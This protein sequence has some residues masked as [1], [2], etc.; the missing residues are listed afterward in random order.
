MHNCDTC[1]GTI[2]FLSSR[3]A[4][5]EYCGRLFETDGD[6]LSSTNAENI[7]NE[8]ISLLKR[9]TEGDLISANELF[10][11]LGSYKDSSG[12]FLESKNLISK[13][14][15]D[16][17]KR[18][19]EEKRNRERADIERKKAERKAREQKR[20]M[21]IVAI[22]ITSIVIVIGTVLFL[23]NSKKKENYQKAYEAYQS[24]DYETALQL[25]TELKQYRDSA[26]MAVSVSQLMADRDN[27]YSKGV[28]YYDEGLY[29]EAII[30]FIS[31]RDYLESSDYIE[32]AAKKI[33]AEAEKLFESENYKEC[34]D[35]LAIITGT[36]SYSAKATALFKKADDALIEIQNAQIYEQ[37]ISFYTAGD[38]ENSQD[39]FVKITD[40]Q[41]A[42][43]YLGSIG[44][45]YYDRAN[46][47]YQKGDYPA[48]CDELQRIDSVEEWVNYLLAKDLYLSASNSY[49]Q[50][51]REEAKSVCRADGE[52][53][54]KKYI[55]GMVCSALDSSAASSLNS[56]CVV[57]SVL[58]HEL[59]AM[60]EGTGFYKTFWEQ[61]MGA[62]SYEPHE[63]NMGNTPQY[64]IVALESTGSLYGGDRLSYNV[65]AIDKQYTVLTGTI[66]VAKGA[67]PD[68][69]L[70]I[71]GDGVVLLKS[72]KMT[73]TTRPYS[74]EVDVSGVMDLRIEVHCGS[75]AGCDPYI[76]TD[77]FK[78]SE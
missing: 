23:I 6:S 37:A 16:A 57:K 77:G 44:Q 53:A 38:Y 54:M 64:Q 19:L 58:L 40:Y 71:Y 34:K 39:L 50:A 46:T 59:N 35:K 20:I 51:V 52:A 49:Q 26:D 47:L 8:A 33:Y 55:D 28:G 76:L 14:R 45:Y 78:L 2:K 48:C 18:I 62:Y 27:T 25:F 9:G 42:K 10:E 36:S 29:Q 5:C 11:A 56:E 60:D 31:V 12:K 1:G 24:S 13:V 30:C 66:S 7:Y 69:W 75:S 17:E 63:D 70:V 67:V 41:D 68:P 4:K 43:D 65:Y 15:V 32:K 3:I 22:S 21:A 73:Q 74:F 61:N 72:P